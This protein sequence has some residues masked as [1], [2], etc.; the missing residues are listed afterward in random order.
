[1]YIPRSCYYRIHRQTNFET[2]KRSPPLCADDKEVDQTG[3]LREKE[4]NKNIS[5]KRAILTFNY[6]VLLKT[7]FFR[8]RLVLVLA[9]LKEQDHGVDWNPLFFL[10]QQG[11][12]LCIDDKESEAAH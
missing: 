8:L 4:I 5:V 2:R 9:P 10:E 1:M 12:M 3:S 11:L 7:R 6:C